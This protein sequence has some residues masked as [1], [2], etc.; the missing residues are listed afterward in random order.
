LRRREFITPV[1]GA[2]AWPRAAPA[3]QPVMPVIGFLHGASS[4]TRAHL[5]AAFQRGVEGAGRIVGRNVGI[6]YRW[7][8][9]QYDRLPALAIDL[10]RRRVAV[11]AVIG[12]PAIFAAKTATSA[13]PIVFMSGDDPV[14]TGLVASLARPG[15]NLTG[16]NLFGSELQA[17]RVGILH[18]LIPG[19]LA[20]AHLM[21]PNFPFAQ[22]MVA[23]VA[24]AVHSLGRQ[25]LL[26]TAGSESDIDA[27]FAT[28][29]EVRAG[30][31]LV[32][33]SPFF[34]SRRNQIVA[35]AARYAIPAIYEW[36]EAPVAGGLVSY[37]PDLPDLFRLVGVYTGP[38]SP[39]IQACRPAGPAAC[40][41]RV[42]DQP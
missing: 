39:G 32:G 14:K 42:G 30:G 4:A 13:I 16:V 6:E 19:D 11:M 24:T 2:V 22:S 33:A 10:V 34:T 26:V 12:E 7:A 17:K 5:I 8:D 15:G 35:L 41:V 20:I 9:N 36:R 3:Q 25:V 29:S 1:G 31:V 40:Q 18:E 37:G 27:A 23:E 28:I 21:D 38:D